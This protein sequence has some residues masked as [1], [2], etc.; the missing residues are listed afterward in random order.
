LSWRYIQKPNLA[1]LSHKKNVRVIVVQ[2]E[3]KG[4]RVRL[5]AKTYIP[6]TLIEVKGARLHSFGRCNDNTSTFS[7]IIF[8]SK[9]HWFI[10]T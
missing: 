1:T 2:F 10:T 6:K 3:S 4:F 7:R 9:H 8:E 5:R